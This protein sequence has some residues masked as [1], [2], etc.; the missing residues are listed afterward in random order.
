MKTLKFI[1]YWEDSS[2]L[3]ESSSKYYILDITIVLSKYKLCSSSCAADVIRSWLSYL[4]WEWQWFSFLDRSLHLKVFVPSK[5]SNQVPVWRSLTQHSDWKSLFEMRKLSA[6]VLIVLLESSSC[7]IVQ[8]LSSNYA[9]VL[10][11][12]GPGYSELSQVDHLFISR[13]ND[14]LESL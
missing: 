9:V 10:G 7:T 12:Y 13:W 1:K 8:T 2:Q 6:L 4:D 5:I 11:G 3:A 14:V